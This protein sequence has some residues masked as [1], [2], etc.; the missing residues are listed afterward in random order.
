MTGPVV[1]GNI[2]CFLKLA[3]TPYLPDP[4]GKIL[5]LESLGGGP[6]RMASLLAQL[7]QMGYLAQ[8]RG[9]LL[10]TFTQMAAQKL[11]PPME[12]LVL[13]VMHGNSIPIAVSPDLGHG[14]DAHC[15]PIGAVVSFQ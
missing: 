6:N 2:R 8:C 4:R 14:D 3:G 10:G 13:D 15:L 7:G 12:E 9:V 11:E 5:F 1:G